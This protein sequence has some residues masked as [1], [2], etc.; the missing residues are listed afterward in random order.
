MLYKKTIFIFRRDLRIHDNKGWNTALSESEKVIPLFIVDPKQV[1]TNKY[2]SA[3]AIDFMIESLNELR[4]EL[5]GNICIKKGKPHEVIEKLV[6]FHKI[7]AIY[8]NID[9]T[10]YSK[11]RDNKIMKVCTRNNCVF[12]QI[13]DILIVGELSYNKSGEAYKVFTPFY[14]E[15]KR[16]KVDEPETRRIRP[17]QISGMYRDRVPIN[18]SGEKKDLQGGRTSALKILRNSS[19]YKEYKKKHDILSY[20]TTRLSPYIKFGCVSIR[21]VY[22]SYK[23]NEMLIR[24]LYWRD[25]YYNLMYND[26]LYGDPIEWPNNKG[27]NEWKRGETGFPV[28]DACMRQLN[29]TGYMHNRGRMIVASFLVKDLMIDWREGEKYFAQKLTEYDWTQNA[30]GWITVAGVMSYSLPYFRVFNPWL[31]S[32][33]YDKKCE[34]IKEWIPELKNVPDMH[35]HEW[36]KNYEKYDVYIRPMLSHEKNKK[37]YLDFYSKHKK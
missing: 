9:Y 16:K 7:E 12:K 11:K 33:K 4:K 35:I 8:S 20:E 10:P 27:F 24:Q 37:K 34:Y 22:K 1:E 18:K 13:H 14:N 26:E 25:F 19:K 30:G 23:N 2:K 6:K 3:R 32:S 21:E 17:G 15:Y 29:K 5:N 31:Q 28:V 36:Y